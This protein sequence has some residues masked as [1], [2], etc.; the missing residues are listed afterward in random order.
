MHIENFT[1]PL[2]WFTLKDYLF[3]LLFFFQRFIFWDLLLL[4]I[5]T[6]SCF[7]K[8]KNQDQDEWN[9]F[10]NTEVQAPVKTGQPHRG[11]W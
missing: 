11:L 10:N 7:I 5:I 1:K 6:D 3:Y 2:Y 8:T 9:I 4:W